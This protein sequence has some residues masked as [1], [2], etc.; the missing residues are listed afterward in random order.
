WHLMAAN[1][2]N[3]NQLRHRQCVGLAVQGPGSRPAGA[4]EFYCEVCRAKRADPFWLVEDSEGI[5]SVI[6]LSSTGKQTSLGCLQLNDPVPYRFHWPLGADLRIN[7]VQYRVYSRNSTQKLGANGRDEPANIGQLWSSAAGGRFHVTMQC[8]DSSVY[9]M[10][11]LLVK[12]RSCEE[13]QGLMAPQLS[14]RDA[15]ERVRQQ[16]AR[17]DD[18][19]LQTGATVV[20]LRCPI[21]GARV[22][23]PARFVE[24]RGLACFDLRAFLDSAARTRKWQCPISMNH[25]TVHSL[26]IDT[27][28]QRIISAL[29]DHPAVMEVEV[30][31][32]G[33][34]RPAGWRDRFY[35][36]T[37]DNPLKAAP[38]A[39]MAGRASAAAPQSTQQQQ[40]VQQPPQRQ[41][42]VTTAAG[43]GSTTAENG[44]GTG[45]GGV[46][47]S[48]R[49]PVSVLGRTNTVRI[50]TSGSPRIPLEGQTP[51]PGVPAITP[52]Q[53][54]VR[55]GLATAIAGSV[56]AW[57]TPVLAGS[58]AAVSQQQ[59]PPSHQPQPQPFPF[60][61]ATSQLQQLQMQQPQLQ[62]SQTQAPTSLTMR[63]V[64]WQQQQQ[65]QDPHTHT[66]LP[67][68]LQQYSASNRQQQQQLGYLHVTTPLGSHQYTHQQQQQQ[69]QQAGGAAPSGARARASANTNGGCA[70]VQG[71]A[72]LNAG[73]NAAV[74]GGAPYE[75]I[76]LLG[77]EDSDEES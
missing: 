58:S 64:Q 30:E 41:S 60:P 40:Q 1:E 61:T 59:P 39:G 42:T 12:R 62:P 8:T 31:A 7:N 16:L 53:P 52:Y 63:N 46:A 29:A 73:G 3:L 43:I 48:H 4:G 17:D 36:V 22:H 65:Q 32:D 13:V 9:V 20:S 67:P 71:G 23:T 28:M 49:Q 76:D 15:V 14:V 50:R 44:N 72:Q 18:D 11:V 19:E 70:R 2:L 27:Y 57:P 74:G 51:P 66:Q 38:T 55:Q 24:V 54:P 75:C 25:S 10:V 69:Q 37:E 68:P 56:A 21:L 35:S 33:S 45:S 26:Q 5:T 47:V 34:W 77:E 6:R